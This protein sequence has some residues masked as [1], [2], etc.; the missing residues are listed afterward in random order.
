M[1]K[2]TKLLEKIASWNLDECTEIRNQMRETLIHNYKQMLGKSEII[3][4]YS[5]IKTDTKNIEKSKLL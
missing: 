4:F 2:I 3:K 5:S 1:D